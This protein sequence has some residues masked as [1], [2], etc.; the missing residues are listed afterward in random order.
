[1]TRQSLVQFVEEYGAKA[2]EI[3]VVFHRGYRTERW[4]YR[5]VYEEACRFARE[6]EALGIEK[7]DAAVLWGAGSG[8]W[9]AAFLGCVLRG[10]VVVP[11]DAGTTAEFMQHVAQET[12]AKLLLCSREIDVTEFPAPKVTLELLGETVAKHS[13]APYVSPR[14]T[15]ADTLEI[16]FTSGTTAEPRGVV[17]SHGNVLANIEPLEIEIKKY[18]KYGRWVH[19]VRFL[20]LL[21]LSHIFGQMMGLFVPPLLGGTILLGESLKPADVVATIRRERVSVLV[22]VPR[23]IESLQHE[24]EREVEAKGQADAF[25]GSFAAAEG[26]HFIR[27][28]WRFRSIHR[29]FGWKFWALVSGG[30][31]LPQKTE[32]FWTRIGY[33][34]VQ[35]YGMTETTALISLNHPFKP[36][37]GSIG[38]AFPG[39]EIKVDST[40]EILVRGENIA[41][42]YR[43]GQQ[44]ET[45]A[46]DDGWF[47]TGDLAEL[48]E[49]GR[50]Y[51]K[52]RRKN[53]I[54]APSG[55]NIYPADLEAALRGQPQVKDC[56]VVG[57][58]RDGNVDAC[59]ALLLAHPGTD[60]AAI[61]RRANRSLAEYQQIRYWFEWPE[62]DFPRTATHKPLL[63]RIAEVANATLATGGSGG[64]RVDSLREALMKI[65]AG[66]GV[67]GSA[68]AMGLEEQLNLSSLDR[69]ELMSALESRYQLDLS[70]A[71]FSEVATVGQLQQLLEKQ[72]AAPAAHAYPRWPQSWLMTQARL[73]A[74]YLLVWPATY[75]LA[76]PKIL[77]RKNLR[78]IEGPVLVVCNHITEIDIGW[79]LAALPTRFR[80][81]MATAMAG[82]G[83]TSMRHPDPRGGV[84][85]RWTLRLGYFLVSVLFN[86]FPLPQQ[87]GF[88]KS[89]W[90]AGDLADRKW[91]ILIFPEGK[92]TQDGRMGEFRG[93]IGLLA[94]RLGLPVVPM[95]ID[96]L[97][98]VK[99]AGR[100]F[101]R[102]GKIQVKIG[103][104]VRFD[105][106]D[107]PAA[108]AQ[109]LQQRVEQL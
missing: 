4:S 3:A 65:G 76:A 24:V 28:W 96:G 59:A 108:V 1:M 48:D 90:F 47:R 19:P 103:D 104:P 73:A 72:P 66:V 78:G 89:F 29:R 52:G 100:K 49:G 86:V 50:L 74:Y 45:T 54:V 41:R 30:A 64:A 81:R 34:V 35:G 94:T 22:G 71:K 80:N 44:T 40:G 2:T 9:I 27:R 93:G 98:E 32:T 97:F 99:Q 33:A 25:R 84:L 37:R 75:L 36:D 79:V 85:R 5:K 107:D 26:N 92:T 16:I 12:S 88:R 23:L 15:R 77:G 105:P 57:I 62:A 95:R 42:S 68:H 63:A 102:P 69:V 82:G 18:L 87:S 31:A 14:M 109:D 70:E 56:V 55:M 20:N 39:V 83:L 21:P 53:V 67:K 10:V 60:T 46:S 58:E 43:R 106:T 101:A 91:S 6:L 38:K 13:E 8:E 51:F 17:I 7:G 61:V 11:L